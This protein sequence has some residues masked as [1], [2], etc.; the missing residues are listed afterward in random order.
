MSNDELSNELL[1]NVLSGRIKMYEIERF[2]D[3][4]NAV[5]I[6]RKAVEKIAGT[7]LK[8]LGAY[9]ISEEPLYGRNI[10]NMIGAVQIPVGIVENVHVKGKYAKGCFY[11]PF[12]TTEGAL[13]ASVNRG[14]SAIA[15]CG[16]AD[17]RIIKEGMTRSAIFSVRDLDEAQI[18]A[19]WISEAE[20]IS[21]MR[22]AVSK[23]SR[24]A[25]LLEVQPFVAGGYVFL[26]FSYDTG[27]AMGMN[28]ATIA[29]DAISSLICKEL[30]VKQIALSGNMCVDKKPAAM[31]LILG[32]GKTVVAQA[33]IDK[34]TAR[35]VLKADLEKMSEACYAKNM[36]GSAMS[37]SLGHNAQVANIAAAIYAACGQDIAHV[38]EASLAI[39]TMRKISKDELLCSLTAPSLQIGTVGGGT[40]I[41]TQRECLSLMGVAGPG[42]SIGNNA[43]KF[44]EIISVVMLAGEISLIAA[45]ASGNLA[46]AH[47]RLGRKKHSV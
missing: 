5:G 47:S 21:S 44:A 33:V 30:G 15:E 31:N 18:L 10:E 29:T 38:V 32:R 23:T 34:E 39:T 19:K 12:A 42:E 8:D 40:A 3:H 11:V 28:M 46:K 25:R 45:L 2:T 9:T 43:R 14:C 6:R 26:R 16:G 36:I 35:H 22:Q 24:I 13:I 41:E 17:A 37:G 4:K 27:D 1:K 7:E 20:N